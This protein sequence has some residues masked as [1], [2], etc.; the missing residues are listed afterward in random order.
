MEADPVPARLRQELSS[1]SATLSSWVGIP[2][3]AW[4]SVCA[5]SVCVV[6]CVGSGLATG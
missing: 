4:K 6:L 3:Q 2:L 1:P 5:Y